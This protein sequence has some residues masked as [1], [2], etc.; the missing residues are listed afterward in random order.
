MRRCCLVSQPNIALR[1]VSFQSNLAHEV[2]YS[3]ACG[4]HTHPRATMASPATVWYCWLDAWVSAAA[5]VVGFGAHT[6]L[7]FRL[8]SFHAPS[9]VLLERAAASSCSSGS[10]S[11]AVS[12]AQ[13]V[14]LGYHA[15][16]LGFVLSGS[17]WYRTEKNRNMLVLGLRMFCVIHA[18]TRMVLQGSQAASVDGATAGQL[19]MSSAW[20]TFLL[21]VGD[22][23]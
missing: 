14:I 13:T 2:G 12:T 21:L 17:K 19:S 15:L 22:H 7:W 8:L 5:I 3:L 4:D 23:A 11:V 20:R 1:F 6:S 9:H 16:L 18:I 10:S